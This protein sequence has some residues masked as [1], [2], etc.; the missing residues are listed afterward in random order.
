MVP[1]T[2]LVKCGMIPPGSRFTFMK[3]RNEFLQDLI[4]ATR[5]LPEAKRIAALEEYIASALNLMDRRTVLQVRRQLDTALFYGP[6]H[7]SIMDLIEGHLA[8]RDIE[9]LPTSLPDRNPLRH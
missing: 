1:M 3:T 5:N 2:D 4:D 9:Q 8:L 7:R 6:E